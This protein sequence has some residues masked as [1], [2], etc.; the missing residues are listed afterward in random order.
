MCQHQSLPIRQSG[1]VVIWPVKEYFL[2][3]CWTSL[4]RPA[5]NQL[6]IFNIMNLSCKL[7]NDTPTN[8]E[9]D[10]RGKGFGDGTEGPKSSPLLSYKTSL[11]DTWNQIQIRESNSTS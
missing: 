3:V 4:D 8:Q 11:G 9:S 2:S 10:E 5:I 1:D 6:Y 7:Q